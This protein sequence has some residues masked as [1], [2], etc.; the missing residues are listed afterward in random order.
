TNLRAVESAAIG[1]HAIALML[2]L[3]RGIDTFVRNQIEGQWRRQD[4]AATR[5]QVL[6]GKTLLVV[7]LGGI[8]TEVAERAHGIGMKVIATRASSR[9]GPDFVSYVGRPDELLEL[10]K[11]ADVIV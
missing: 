3:A 7:G 5:M 4:A 2:A 11:T 8:G 10:A 9:T 6:S 1:E